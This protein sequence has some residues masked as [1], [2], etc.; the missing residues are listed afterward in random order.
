MIKVYKWMN[1]YN[2]GDINGVLNV[3]THDRMRNNW[4]SLDL[5]NTWVNTGSVTGLLICGTNY[6]ET[7][8]RWGSSTVSS[9]GW[10]CI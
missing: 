9:M 6:H 1:G 8:W 2:T 3:S 7:Q 5:G 4:I 10:T